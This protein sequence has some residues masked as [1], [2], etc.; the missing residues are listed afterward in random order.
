MLS[1]DLSICKTHTSRASGRA[2][3]R[4]TSKKAPWL[5]N[6]HISSTMPK[7]EVGS[8][9][10][11]PPETWHRCSFKIIRYWWG[12][13]RDSPSNFTNVLI[14]DNVAEQGVALSFGRSL[15]FWINTEQQY[16]LFRWSCMDRKCRRGLV[17]EHI[18]KFRPRWCSMD[19][20]AAH[21]PAHTQT[22]RITVDFQQRA[23]YRWR[24]Q[25]RDL[26]TFT[27]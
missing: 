10:R 20:G 16:G 27:G 14:N 13:S 26:G 23:Q 21:S 22:L 25:Y 19:Q 6:T 17:G 7:K 2:R 3:W 4:Y 9:P 11:K 15:N 5:E 1:L 8:I 12:C 24:H 18:G